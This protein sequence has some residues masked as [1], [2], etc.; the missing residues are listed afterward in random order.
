MT[1]HCCSTALAAPLLWH[2]HCTVMSGWQSCRPSQSRSRSCPR[3]LQSKS[4]VP[5]S[6]RQA[7]GVDRTP[8]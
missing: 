8:N 6:F 1:W 2:R 7:S 5:R 3:P 4:T